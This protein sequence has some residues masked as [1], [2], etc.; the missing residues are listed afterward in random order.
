MFSCKYCEI[1]KNRFFQWTPLVTASAVLNLRVKDIALSAS[2]DPKGDTATPVSENFCILRKKSELTNLKCQSCY[3]VDPLNV[4]LHFSKCCTIFLIL[5][6]NGYHH[7]SHHFYISL[8]KQKQLFSNN[9]TCFNGSTVNHC[10]PS[11]RSKSKILCYKLFIK[12]KKEI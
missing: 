9:A 7:L 1:F 8:K 12:I 2:I 11:Y 10:Q 5:D 4:P 3:L 6:G